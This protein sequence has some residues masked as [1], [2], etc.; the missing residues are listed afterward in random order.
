MTCDCDLD[1]KFGRVIR[2]NNQV[3]GIVEFKDCDSKASSN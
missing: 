3:T 1:K 2:N